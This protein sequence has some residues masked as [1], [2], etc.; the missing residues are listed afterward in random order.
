LAPETWLQGVSEGLQLQGS[1]L[2]TGPDLYNA[3][4]KAWNIEG[5]GPFPFAFAF[6]NGI[7]TPLFMA[8]SGSG[9][10]PQMTLFTLLLLA[11]RTWNPISGLI[12]GL[13]L[14]SLAL[15]G[16]HLFVMLWPGIFLA[17]LVGWFVGRQN[18]RHNPAIHGWIWMFIPGLLLT[19]FMGGVLTEFFERTLISLGGQAAT[20]SV[21]LP[22]LGLRWP[23]SFISAHL[24]SLSLTSPGQ[25]IVALAEMGPVLLLI[26]LV[27]CLCWKY[28]RQGKWV[29]AGLGIAAAMGF[30]AAMFISFNQ[31]ERDLSRLTGAA[32]FIWLVLGLPYIWLALKRGRN[33]T[34]QY[35]L[36][37]AVFL[38]IFGGLALFPTHLIAITR[39]Q[40]S[41]FV[42][43]P[44]ALM[45]AQYWDQ[46]EPEAQVID[47]GYTHRAPTLFGRSAGQ[48]YENIYIRLSAY[49]ALLNDPNPN[50]IA[51]AGYSYIYLDKRTWLEFTND[52]RQAFR[53]SC[54]KIM[55]EKRTEMNDFRRL[56]DIR[57]CN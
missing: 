11:R 26:P 45:S 53:T 54:V 17:V 3:L 33:R 2:Q 32:L 56:L 14:T 27:S 49:R 9:A 46:L 13:L 4:P 20:S 40:P 36:I 30:L 24:G 47:L 8:L 15:T 28:I 34:Q 23:P 25:I 55:D 7:F 12:Y 48:A 1:A 41:F 51:E 22:E 52:Q 5:D 39:N 10:L 35:I 50:R 57:T 42:E 43:Q 31:R 19:P 44:D 16:E 18:G 6:T 21:A 29:P 38:T 37:C